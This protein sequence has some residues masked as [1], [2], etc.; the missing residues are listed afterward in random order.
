MEVEFQIKS[1]LKWEFTVLVHLYTEILQ[2]VC[3]ILQIQICQ[4]YFVSDQAESL[5]KHKLET[6]INTHKTNSDFPI[7]SLSVDIRLVPHPSQK[8]T[9]I[10]ERQF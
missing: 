4:M 5:K 10:L 9:V 1:Y 2:I 3:F 6:R 8:K 7:V